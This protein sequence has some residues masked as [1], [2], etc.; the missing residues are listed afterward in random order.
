MSLV[1]IIIICSTLFSSCQEQKMEEKFDWSGTLSAPQEYPIEVYKGSLKT[2]DFTQHFK[3]WGIINTGWGNQGG[4]MIVG[5]DKK[6]VPATL[7][8]S[9]LSFA[10]N[11]FYEGKFDLPKEKL[12]AL[13]K[14]GFI[15]PITKEK[16]TYKN[17]V[18]GLAPKGTVVVW[19]L[20]TGIQTQVARFKAHETQIDIESVSSDD[21]YM[22]DKSYA[23][24]VLADPM[25]IRPEIKEKLNAEGYP[26]ATIYEAY[27]KKYSW[28]PKLELP[29]E[30]ATF[31]AFETCNGEKEFSGSADNFKNSNRAVPYL[32]FIN[33][34]DNTGQKF[35]AWLALT[36]DENYWKKYKNGGISKLPLDFEKSEIKSVFEEKLDTK[37]A[38]EIIARV[39]NENTDVSLVIKQNGKEILLKDVVKVIGKN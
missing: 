12:T 30:Q 3:N 19:L 24:S 35:T 18:I 22:F 31:F 29:N 4:T 14:Q 34:K 15:D 7:E 9:W 10:E 21:R 2:S 38:S 5:P 36:K 25:I 37:S 20:S 1:T 6:A 16:E 27:E 26:S 32:F 11:K 28:S 33:W 39:N 13:F 17:I 8:I 23:A